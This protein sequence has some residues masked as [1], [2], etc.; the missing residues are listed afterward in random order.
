MVCAGVTQ[1][2]PAKTT[3]SNQVLDMV[4]EV[5]AKASGRSRGG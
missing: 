1:M 4:A 3:C 2:R 5:S